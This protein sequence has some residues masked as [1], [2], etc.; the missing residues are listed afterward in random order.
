MA[1]RKKLAI[2]TTVW[3]WRS[4]ANH[5]GERFLVGYPR[6]GRWHRPDFDIVGAYVDQRDGDDDLSGHRPE[7][8][9]FTLYPPITE[10]PCLGPCLL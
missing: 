8:F 9:G 5:M 3:D 2:I 6:D 10:A 1:Q 7:E 4:H